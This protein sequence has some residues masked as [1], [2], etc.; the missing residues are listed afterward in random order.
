MT[1]T[2]NIAAHCASDKQV[3]VTVKDMVTGAI[4]ESFILQDGEKADRVV[5][6][7]RQILTNEVLK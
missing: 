1:T 6:D 3:V 2:V 4:H 7:N 5:Y